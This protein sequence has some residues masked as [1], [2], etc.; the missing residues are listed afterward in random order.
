MQ[1]RKAVAAIKWN[2]LALWG[3]LGI[4]VA[5]CAGVVLA[6]TG[7]IHLTWKDWLLVGIL[8]YGRALFVAAGYHR[9]FSHRAF[10]LRYQ[11]F[12]QFILA[13]LAQSSIQRGALWWASTHRLH[14]RYTDEPRDPHSPLQRGFWYSHVG[15]IIARKAEPGPIPDFEKYPE[16]R[17]LDR[18]HWIPGTFLG[19]FC[20]LFG[21]WNGL[22]AFFLS[23]VC[24]SHGTFTVNSVAHW[25]GIVVKKTENLR[26]NHPWLRL[27]IALL[28]YR[29]H[30]TKDTSAN[31]PGLSVVVVGEQWHNDHHA[32]QGLVRQGERWWEID[33]TYYFIRLLWLLG[34]AKNL[35]TAT[36]K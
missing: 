30:K 1:I 8:Y 3:F 26:R 9:Y 18:W 32:H 22:F 11:R 7:I 14:H 4:H 24:L 27:S 36:A 23:T 20:L 2:S 35:K 25:V 19:F 5:A 33:F 12:S 16:L 17:W 29:R 28:G 10:E 21:G 31:V 15:W 34:I 6:L 13:F